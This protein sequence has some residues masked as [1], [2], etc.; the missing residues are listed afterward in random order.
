MTI[1]EVLLPEFDQEM[2]TTRKVLERI[3][4]GALDWKPHEKSMSMGDLA[5]HLVN[6]P[7]WTGMTIKTDSFDVSPPGGEAFHIPP[8]TSRKEAL[9]MFD[10]NVTDARAAIAGAG[11]DVWMQPW[12]L[13]A[14]GQVAFTM[15]KAAVMRGFV[16]SHGIHHRGQMSVYLRLRDIPVPSIYGPSADDSGM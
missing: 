12:S 7:S 14:G 3:D 9:E 13:L 10:R 11:D 2:A 4:D 8:V 15:P 6:I 16:L 1:S 5:T